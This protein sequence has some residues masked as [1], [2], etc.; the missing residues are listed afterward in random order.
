[1]KNNFIRTLIVIFVGV[2]IWFSPVPTGL[3]PQ[4]WHLFAI[5]VTTILG[6]VLQPMPMGAFAFVALTFTMLMRVL[7]P[8]EVLS[9]FSTSTI[10][11]I[12]SAFTF[13]RGIIKTGLGR[14]TAFVLM[15]NMGDSTL[16]LAYTL[17]ITDLII[18]PATPS[19]T[20]RGGGIVFP[21][22][23]SLASAFESEP[24]PT[25]RRM[26]A[27]LMTNS[28]QASTITSAMFMTSCAPNPLL[29]ALAATTLGA[30]ITWGS[31]AIAA[32]VPGLIS[33][34]VMPYVI[35][36]L[37]PPE[38]TKTPEAKQIAEKELAKMGPMSLGEK[39][40]GL[41]FIGAITLWSTSTL[42]KIDATAVAML[43]VSAILVTRVL[44]WQDV[45]NE[46]GSWDTLV[47]LGGLLGLADYLDRLGFGKWFAQLAS[48]MMHGIPW[49]PTLAI[50]LLIYCYSHYFFAG[51]SSH[52]VAL[53]TVLSLVAM[54]AGAPKYLVVFSMIF[55]SN[56]VAGLT[57]YSTGVAPIF[58]GAGFVDQHTWWRLGFI[59]SVVNL[60]I[61]V[62]I[63]G[64]WWKV[65]GLW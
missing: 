54:G 19:N 20:A 39:I 57:N 42:T 58:Y 26:G 35:Y 52:E 45:L 17:A 53:F 3:K 7:K 64:V 48:S 32:V 56:L 47:W 10:W 33:L 61:W 31:W 55:V 62:G 6:F 46:K 2:V 44:D 23:R 49:I 18:S 34:A 12:V 65:L 22:A 16:K 36:R 63:G 14:R 43:A 59:M 24:G 37:Y 1:M 15:K 50:V 13:S 29:V 5:F 28:F 4:T 21:I 11:L 8:T 30:T 40:V 41:V 51:L 38:V 60:V 25:S 9:G 27:Y